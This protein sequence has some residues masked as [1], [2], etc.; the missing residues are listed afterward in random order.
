[1]VK[2]ILSV[3]GPHLKHLTL[4][5]CKEINLQDLMPCLQLETLCLQMKSTLDLEESD[6]ISEPE[7]FLPQLK[8][9]ESDICL[10]A[11][12]HLFEEKPDLTRVVLN[13]YH[14]GIK[15]IALLALRVS[16]SYFIKIIY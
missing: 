7:S 14:V 9:L 12:S 3:F 15:V 8:S 2:S 5:S 1:M 13:C 16:L 11:L 4:E 6:P 10:G